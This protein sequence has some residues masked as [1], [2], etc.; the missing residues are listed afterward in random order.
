[1]TPM[2]SN[3]QSRFINDLG[4]I[5]IPLQDLARVNDH[6]NGLGEICDWTTC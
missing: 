6:H 1:M 5:I 4:F 2:A 3:R